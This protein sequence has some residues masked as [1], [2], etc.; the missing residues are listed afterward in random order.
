MTHRNQNLYGIYQHQIEVHPLQPPLEPPQNNQNIA[1][2][3]SEI[4]DKGVLSTHQDDAEK[5]E[6]VENPL[7]SK[8]LDEKSTSR[9]IDHSQEIIKIDQYSFNMFVPV[10]ELDEEG[11]HNDQN[12]CL[13]CTASLT[14]DDTRA[15]PCKHAFH[16]KCIYE[17]MVIYNN[18]TC[19]SCKRQYY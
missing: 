18:K 14:N 9:Y 10:V 3:N 12:T 8:K 17:M 16:G 15:L 7:S 5:I 19:P 1:P 4:N 11:K 6:H 2:I 13:I